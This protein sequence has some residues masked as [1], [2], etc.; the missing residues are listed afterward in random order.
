MKYNK[1]M[2]WPLKNINKIPKKP[3]PAAFG[4]IRKFDIHTGVD[5]YCNPGDSVVS[6]LD[7]E[8]FDVKGVIL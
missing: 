3:H 2:Y 7:G 4:S 1:N 8:V 6:I 5:L